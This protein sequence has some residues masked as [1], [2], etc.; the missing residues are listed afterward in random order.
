MMEKHYLIVFYGE[1]K[2]LFDG[3]SSL[4]KTWFMM[5]QEW[6]D[7]QITDEELILF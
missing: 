1:K 4:K 3:V 6:I 7:T 2:K 5:I